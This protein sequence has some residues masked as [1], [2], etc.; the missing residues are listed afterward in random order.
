MLRLTSLRVLREYALTI[1]RYERG[2]DSAQGSDSSQEDEMPQRFINGCMGDTREAKRR[3]DIT[4]K[5][6][7]QERIDEIMDE[8]QPH[9]DVIKEFYPHYYCGRGK[10]N[11][12]VYYES[13]GQVIDPLPCVCLDP[14]HSFL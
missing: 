11:Q 1:I 10:Q 2:D 8:P 9:F 5:W 6:R 4:K 3:W 12:P 7:K 13:P 14:N